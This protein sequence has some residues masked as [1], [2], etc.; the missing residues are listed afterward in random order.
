M[1]SGETRCLCHVCKRFLHI[2]RDKFTAPFPNYYNALQKEQKKG[3]FA[4]RISLS[5][6][7]SL[8]SGVYWELCS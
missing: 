7:K 2:S 1:W 5:L 3:L 8:R 6:H 4:R